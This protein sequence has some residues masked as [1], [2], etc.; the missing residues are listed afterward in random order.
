M[1]ARLLRCG[2]SLAAWN[3]T[4]EKAEALRPL[5]AKVCATPAEV[6]AE[7]DGAIL[8]LADARAIEAVLFEPGVPLA[9]RTVVQMGTIGP[10]QSVQVRDHV[11]QA[12]GRYLE[13]PV[14]GSIP[15]AEA[16]ELIVMVGADEPL[17]ER[18]RDL[19]SK[20]GPVVEVGA[21]G[22]AATL[23]LALNHLIGVHSAAFAT[24][25]GLV[26]RAGVEVDLFMQVLRR[27]NLYAPVFD[28]KL[29][30]MLA[31]EF[32]NPHFPTRLLRKDLQLFCDAA[33]R[34]GVRP[35]VATAV[36]RLL[37][38]AVQAGLADCDYAAL[39]EVVDPR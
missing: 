31:R 5:G 15:Q 36:V 1:A 9:N 34:H 14:M 22:S 35:V 3:R 30:S 2:V 37:E 8:M 39:C 12:G 4:R 19:L 16:G 18:W 7:T 13:A 25:L 26:R 29:P 6:F 32:Q 10:D 24:S 11:L 38:E 20:L 33:E 21:V 28:K 27:T 17:D 23:K